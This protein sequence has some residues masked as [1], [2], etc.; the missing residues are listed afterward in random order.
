MD[1]TL[2][3]EQKRCTIL[4][5][6]IDNRYREEIPDIVDLVVN[7]CSDKGCFDHLDSAVIPSKEALTEIIDLIRDILFPGYF[8]DQTVDR[9]T[10]SYHVGNEITELF[11]KLSEQIT[12][13]I[14]HECKRY[15][16]EC[17][18]CVDRGQEET[19]MFLKKIPEIRSMLA[20]DIIATYEGDP[21]AK[22]Y[23]EIIFSYPGIFAM[24]VYRAAHE[25]HR[26]GISI[27]PRIMTE[28]AH[29][30]VGI[31]IH[32][33]AKIGKG[34][35]IDHGTGVVIGETCE[36]GNNVRIYQGVTLGSLSFPKDESGRI[37]RDQKRHPTIEDDVIIYSNATILGGD[38]VIGARSVI[39]GNVWITESV[40]ADTKVIIEEP[41]LIFKEKKH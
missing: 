23:D 27:I 30:A 1:K 19:L 37:I 39:G 32:P 17:T 26:Q 41:R 34:F 3:P 33:G 5:S 14:I 4:D 15:E 22:N 12:N 24:T 35:F 9:N 18:E 38:T 36:I 7:S 2:A 13:S 11:N 40:P 16:E 21:A 31:D 8:G 10:L 6:M 20:S 28:Y 29:S 25:L